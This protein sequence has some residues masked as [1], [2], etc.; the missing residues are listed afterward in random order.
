MFKEGISRQIPTSQPWLG[1]ECLPQRTVGNERLPR[2]KGLWLVV[3]GLGKGR[4]MG[5]V[6]YKNAFGIT[7]S[8]T[9]EKKNLIS[10]IT[11]K[12]PN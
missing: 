4:S 7:I 10:S 11:E 2:I 6:P 1:D 3:V 9:K 12:C 5:F 8:K